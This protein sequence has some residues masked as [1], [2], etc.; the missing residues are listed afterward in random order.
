MKE[1]L[2]KYLSELSIEDLKRLGGIKFLFDPDTIA[3]LPDGRYKLGEYF[4]GSKDIVFY[5]SIIEPKDYRK[6]IVHEIAH[7]FGMKHGMTDK[8]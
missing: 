7:Y 4:E 2:L 5:T 8:Y 3:I 6:V 1:E